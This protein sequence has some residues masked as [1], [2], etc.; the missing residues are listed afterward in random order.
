MD[1][2]EIQ[3]IVRVA[4]EPYPYQHPENVPE[5]S[6]PLVAPVEPDQE[7]VLVPR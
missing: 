1:I 2:G 5:E 7:P 6:N 4:P 3:R